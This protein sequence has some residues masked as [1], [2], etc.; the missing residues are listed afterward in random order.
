MPAVPLP[1]L[2]LSLGSETCQ[3]QCEKYFLSFLGRRK[4]KY[5]F[6]NNNPFVLLYKNEKNVS[7]THFL[8][9][10]FHHCHGKC[11]YIVFCQTFRRCERSR[12]S[13]R[14]G[15]SCHVLF[16]LFSFLAK[17]WIFD[18]QRHCFANYYRM[19]SSS[20]LAWFVVKS[21]KRRW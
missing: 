3:Y 5:V 17:F 21:P 12:R 1:L 6:T 7:S 10:S 15:K 14:A 9:P 18:G 4:K 2:L 19:K 16:C 20:P 13:N 11:S 8:P